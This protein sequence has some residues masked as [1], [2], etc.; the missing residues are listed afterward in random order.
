MLH[1]NIE[2]TWRPKILQCL[3][4]YFYTYVFEIKIQRHQ[5]R[6]GIIFAVSVNCTQSTSFLKSKKIELKTH[7]PYTFTPIKGKLEV[8]RLQGFHRTYATGVAC[9]QMTLT[10][11]DTWSC[12]TLGLACV[13]M[14]RPISPELFLFPDF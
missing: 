10:P 7:N 13:L 9:Q 12:P 3:N 1:N 5:C 8:C 11:P 2:I 6:P 4:V 14:S